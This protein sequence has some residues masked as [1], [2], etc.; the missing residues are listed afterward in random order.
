MHD[1]GSFVFGLEVLCFEFWFS[2]SL[3]LILRSLSWRSGNP[4][5]IRLVRDI[6]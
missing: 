5:A 2:T 6:K 4:D 1:L 3:D